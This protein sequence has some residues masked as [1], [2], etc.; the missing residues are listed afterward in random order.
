MKFATAALASC[1]NAA[2]APASGA[3]TISGQFFV[4][5]VWSG[6]TTPAWP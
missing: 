3:A 5:M 6:V 1:P 2:S 4:R